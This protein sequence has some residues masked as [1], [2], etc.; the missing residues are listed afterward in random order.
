MNAINQVLNVAG[1][2]VGLC[3]VAN[4]RASAD[5]KSASQ[6]LSALRIVFAPLAGAAPQ[7]ADPLGITQGTQLIKIV[8]DPSVETA[9]SASVA[10]A[11]PAAK[12]PTLPHTGAGA[13][14]TIV[15][16]I[17]VAGGALFLRRRLA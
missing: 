10:Q 16:G 4:Q 17:G 7:V 11:A 3:D 14:A 5:G 12:A 8:I 2:Q 1:L 6:T 15:T 9:A 13:L